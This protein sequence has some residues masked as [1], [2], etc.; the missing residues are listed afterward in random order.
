MNSTIDLDAVL[1]NLDPWDLT[2]TIGGTAHRVRPLTLD[3][4][5]RLP[6]VAEGTVEQ[7]IELLGGIFETPGPDVGKWDPFTLITVV[8]VVVEHHAK[9]AEMNAKKMAKADGGEGS[10]KPRR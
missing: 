8:R 4:I 2:L 10:K 7:A 6:K 5:V 1:A 9:W 3:Q